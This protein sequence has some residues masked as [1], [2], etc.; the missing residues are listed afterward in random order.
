MRVLWSMIVAV[1]LSLAPTAWAQEKPTVILSTYAAWGPCLHWS[2]TH[3]ASWRASAQFER[4]NYRYIYAHQWRMMLTEQNWLPTLPNWDPSLVWVL[5]SFL[6]DQARWKALDP[7]ANQERH[8]EYY[9]PRFF[10]S[11]SSGSDALAGAVNPDGRFAAGNSGGASGLVVSWSG[12]AQWAPNR[13]SGS[14]TW[15]GR[16]S[17]T[18]AGSWT[19]D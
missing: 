14:G 2:R 17:Y 19:S 11:G 16:G 1:M 12:R 18:C 5:R 9:S 3:E 6:A 4:V 15:A 10:V 13:W 7:G 8:F